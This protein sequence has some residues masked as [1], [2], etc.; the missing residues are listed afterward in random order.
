MN[1]TK[2]QFRHKLK[3][4]DLT[5]TLIAMSNTGKTFWSKKLEK[6]GFENFCCDDL[7]EEKLEPELKKQGFK[8]IADVA[9]WLGYPYQDHFKKNEQTYLNFEIQTMKTIINHLEKRDGN[10]STV[11]DT[12]GSVIYSGTDV[13]NN[14]NQSSFIVYIKTPEKMIEEMIENYFKMPK[15]VLWMD[16]FEQKTSETEEE[17]LKACYPNLLRS[18]D[19]LYTKSCNQ[20]VPYESFREDMSAEEFLETIISQL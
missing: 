12:T 19:K 7:I 15:P 9:K 18:R 13:L 10:S 17:A 1:L 4:N 16:N 8:G 20:V 11:I 6:I 5:I 3:D 2:E 14:L